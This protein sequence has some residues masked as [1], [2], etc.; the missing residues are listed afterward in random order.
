MSFVLS[1]F[2][3]S[4]NS[5]DAKQLQ[6][7]EDRGP[8]SVQVD[9]QSGKSGNSSHSLPAGQLSH[10][11]GI[12]YQVIDAHKSIL[13]SSENGLEKSSFDAPQHN[14]SSSTIGGQQLPVN[15][16]DSLKSIDG[17]AS[18]LGNNDLGV[19][20]IKEEVLLNMSYYMIP[21]FLWPPP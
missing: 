6:F 4:A 9:P 2:I 3:A 11:S 20:D 14:S 5:N 10:G 21:I 16:E 17:A 12:V 18:L 1:T 19:D 8:K 13:D 7:S 15:L